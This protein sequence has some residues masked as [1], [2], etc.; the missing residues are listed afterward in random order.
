MAF[1]PVPPKPQFPEIERRLLALWAED[2]I[3]ERSIAESESKPAFVFYEG[4]PTANGMPHPGH[5]LTRAAKDVILRYRSMTGWYVPRRG[6]WDT[7]GLPVE[8]EVEKE[9]GINGRHGIE[10]YGVEAFTHR[11]IESVFRYID[12]W[13]KLTERIA[14]WVDLDRAYVTFHKPYIESVWWALAR[15]FDE[16]LLYQDYKIV[17]WWP[18]GGTALS[19]GEVGQGYRDVDDPS[20]F[21]RFA[22][23]GE[24]KT[25]FLA[26]TTT[27]WTLP[28]NV[29]LAVHEKFDYATVE[30]RSE[31][32]ETERLILAE[33]LIPKVLGDREHTVIATRKGRELEG[34]KYRA[35]FSY[36]AP[37][38]GAAHVVVTADYV[39]LEAG[40]G[41]VH[42]APAFGEDDFRV[43]KEKK[44]GFLQLVRPD[45]TFD[46]RVTDFAG[47]F[48]KEADRD[49]IRNLRARD[50]LF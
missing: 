15:M 30:V 14:F 27:P 26:W 40:S 48:C 50:L 9:L 43:A 10:A 25:S 22:V 1:Q 35:P 7:H 31:S 4:P 45:G 38:G 49:I 32:G 29:A 13:R 5:A 2:R 47:R 28:S 18:Q 21:V 6:G 20:I 37:E 44:L 19:A 42:T 8:V 17:W 36:A 41:I 39:S 34:M 12:E 33:K 16:G 3:F 24:E 46:E 23:E 11:C